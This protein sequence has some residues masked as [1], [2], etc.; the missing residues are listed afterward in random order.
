MGATLNALINDAWHAI[1]EYHK[2]QLKAPIFVFSAANTSKLQSQE[3]V[4]PT[5]Y[6]DKHKTELI[7]TSILQSRSTSQTLNSVF[8]EQNS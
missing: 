3:P 6:P 7:K 1:T 8:L 4:K 2:L 5:R